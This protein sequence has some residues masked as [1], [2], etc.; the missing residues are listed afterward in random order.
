MLSTLFPQAH[1]RYASL[2]VVGRT[3]EEFCIWLDARGYP[4]EAIRRR[5][6]G[7]RLLASALRRRRVHRLR[8]LTA[9]ELRSFAPRPTRWTAQLACSL[10][11]SLTQFLQERAALATPPLTPAGE[12]VATYARYLTTVRGLAPQTVIRHSTRVFEFLRFLRYDAQPQRLRALQLADVEAFMGKFGGR[13]GRASM[14]KVSAVLRSFLRFLAAQGVLPPGLDARIDSP[15]CFRGERLPRAL[16]WEKVRQLLGAV[17]RTTPKGKRDYAMLLMIGSYGLRASE[18]ATLKL[19]DVCWRSRSMRVPRPKVGSPLSLPLTDEVATALL[20]YL[21]HGRP[22]SAH[23]QLFLRVRIPLGP[24]ESTAVTDVFETW[25]A[26]IG[27]RLP[28][29]AGGPHCLRHSIAV[30]LLRKGATLK[31]IGDLLGHRSAE[32]T[33]VYLRLQL[34]DLRNVALPLPALA[35]EVK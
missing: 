9:P 19:D 14:Q 7:A 28:A 20:D 4:P 13:L 27:L 24:I 21:S 3:L 29:G 26:R 35:P 32:S 23:R 31:A 22:P 34:D 17:D 25:A 2:P 15:R 11:R 8:D 33:S 30:H 12:Q 18:I 1:V 5:I 10:V 6:R 16:P